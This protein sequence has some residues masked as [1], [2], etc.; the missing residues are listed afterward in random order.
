MYQNDN[1]CVRIGDKV[2]ETFPVSIGVKQGDNPSPTLFNFYLSDLP[3]TFNSS[4]TCPPVLQDGTPVGYLLWAYDLVILSKSEEGLRRALNK[5][6]HSLYIYHLATVVDFSSEK[7]SGSTG[8]RNSWYQQ[9][10]LL[11]GCRWWDS[12]SQPLGY[13][14]SALAIELTSSIAVA[15]KELSLYSWC[16]ASLYIYHFATVVDFSSEKYSGSTG[17]GNSWYQQRNLQWGCRW[18][19][20]NSQPLGYKPSALAIELTSSKAVAGKE[21]S[22]YSRCIASLYIYHVDFIDHSV[23]NRGVA[24]SSLTIGKREHCCD[25]N[26][27]KINT[28]KSKCMIF[29]SRGRTIT[30]RFIYKSKV[31]KVVRNYMYL[32]F[33]R[34]ISGKINDG[35]LDLASSKSSESPL[36]TEKSNG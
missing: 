1:A 11:W 18:W 7:Y 3:E 14:P 21:L 15:G 17:H 9:R 5:L 19:D 24:S 25:S 28:T 2:T 10:N 23:Y 35:L 12:N 34:S 4:D 26:L 13:K 6:E 33:N 8:Y 29:K 30:K 27:L 16:I 32:G 20:S 31:L 22:L 36:Q